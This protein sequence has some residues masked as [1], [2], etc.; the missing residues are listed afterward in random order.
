MSEPPVS[1]PDTH[2]G[3]CCVDEDCPGLYDMALHTLC[4]KHRREAQEWSKAHEA[5]VD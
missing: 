3:G 5:G 1:P 2:C 4:R